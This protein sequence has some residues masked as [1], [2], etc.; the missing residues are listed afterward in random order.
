VK[1]VAG[2]FGCLA[3]LFLILT[4]ATGTLMS[5]AFQMMPPEMVAS[6][7]QYTWIVQDVNG[8]CCCLSGVMCIV[9]LA[10]SAMRSRDPIE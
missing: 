5:I 3:F 1:Y 8:G 2:C 7:G 10:A 9:L 4:F 6:F